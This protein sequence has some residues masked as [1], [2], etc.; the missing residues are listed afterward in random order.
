MHMSLN[1]LEYNEETKE[2][3]GPIFQSEVILK[4]GENGHYPCAN[5]SVVVVVVPPLP[6]CRWRSSIQK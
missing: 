3:I 4:D 5:V 1:V 2:I 6:L